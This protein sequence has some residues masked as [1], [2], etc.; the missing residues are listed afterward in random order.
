LDQQL[1]SPAIEPLKV[2]LIRMET[3][4]RERD[5]TAPELP[6]AAAVLEPET[7]ARIV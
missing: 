6:F 2:G 3:A 4:L 1:P 7:L 5:H